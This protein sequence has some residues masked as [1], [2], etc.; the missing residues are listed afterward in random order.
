MSYR[1]IILTALSL[2]LA[3]CVTTDEERAAQNAA[4]QARF[5][6]SRTPEAI[7]SLRPVIETCVDAVLT[8]QNPSQTAGSNIGASAEMW[9]RPV[10]N[11]GGVQR[12]CQINVPN[13]GPNVQSAG[14]LIT[15]IAERQGYLSKSRNRGTLV[16]ERGS[17]RLEFS[18][19]LQAGARGQQTLYVQL[20]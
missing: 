18:S 10:V 1:F 7:N 3:G 6:A 13:S 16:F 11:L 15:E 14:A 12:T 19:L 5:E 17:S 2:G 9:R 4:S 8:G 20:F